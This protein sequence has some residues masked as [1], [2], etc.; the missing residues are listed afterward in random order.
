M[1]AIMERPIQ[2]VSIA[3]GKL[4]TGGSRL[5]VCQMQKGR[6]KASNDWL[7]DEVLIL[8]AGMVAESH[9]TGAYCPHGA[10]Q[11]LRAI[12]RLTQTRGGSEQQ[13]KR[14]QRRMLDKTEHLLSDETIAQAIRL[15]AEELLAKTTI[16]GRLVK[17]FLAQAKSQSGCD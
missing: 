5:G 15:V 1:A 4:Q 9:F 17:H 14:I 6:R 11:D 16:S 3:P 10:G 2:K 8:F 7:E 13:L 12:S